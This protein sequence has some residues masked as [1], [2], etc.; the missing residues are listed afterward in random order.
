MI[1]AILGGSEGRPENRLNHILT[2]AYMDYCFGIEYLWWYLAR[3]G[4]DGTDGN[5]NWLCEL[6]KED[7]QESLG[8]EW[9]VWYR[10]FDF[11]EELCK[12]TDWSADHMSLR[13]DGV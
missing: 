6:D 13:F 10:L 7:L 4:V 2:N 5:Y 12:E 1:W 11:Q 8:C 3:N 9:K